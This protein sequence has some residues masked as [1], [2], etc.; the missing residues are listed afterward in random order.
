MLSW[1]VSPCHLAM[2]IRSAFIV[3]S[4]TG[5]P[6][7]S[8]GLTWRAVFVRERPHL[9]LSWWVCLLNNTLNLLSESSLIA[10]RAGFFLSSPL[11]YC[12]ESIVSFVS[13]ARTLIY[14]PH[15]DIVSAFSHNKAWMS[16]VDIVR[17]Q[18]PPS[19]LS[20]LSEYWVA[21]FILRYGSHGHEVL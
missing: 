4:W 5:F 19:S 6:L 12:R 7:M 9:L 13:S 17:R 10:F 1:V 20:G 2:P 3:F 8:Y 11:D 21:H 16:S 15:R 18:C 14:L